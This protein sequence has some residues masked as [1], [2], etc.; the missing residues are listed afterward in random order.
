MLFRSSSEIVKQIGIESPVNFT[1]SRSLLSLLELIC[2]R[3]DLKEI[4]LKSLKWVLLKNDIEEILSTGK[5]LTVLYEKYEKVFLPEAWEQNV[6]EIR[7]NILAHG[8]KW[9]K[10]IISDYK[11]SNKQLASL[12]KEALPKES[13]L[14]LEYLDAILQAKRH[15]VILKEY[16]PLIEELFLLNQVVGKL[17]L[18]GLINFSI[19]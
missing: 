7:Q 16:Q 12:S 14:K 11:K 4:N 18:R 1:Q 6:L 2:Q 5:S 19:A 13:N 3:P 15:E 17:I 10:F 8:H 9:Y